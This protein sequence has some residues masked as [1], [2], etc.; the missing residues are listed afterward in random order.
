MM[1]LIMHQD[2]GLRFPCNGRTDKVNKLFIMWPFHYGPVP[3]INIKSNNWSVDN[4]KK[5]PRPLN[6]LNT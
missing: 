4:L 6:E 5:K 1:Y 2:Q 3:G